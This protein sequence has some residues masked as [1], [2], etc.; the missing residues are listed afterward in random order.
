MSSTQVE[1]DIDT[2]AI[3]CKAVDPATT[4]TGLDKPATAAKEAHDHGVD[5]D[6][7]PPERGGVRDSSSP[8]CLEEPY[9]TFLGSKVFGNVYP[10]TIVPES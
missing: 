7:A 8:V 10:G 9:L 4:T 5:T 1:I 2:R 3:K 6:G